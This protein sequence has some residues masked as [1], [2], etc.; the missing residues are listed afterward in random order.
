M[1]CNDLNI[2]AIGNWNVCDFQNPESLLSK[3]RMSPVYS[4]GKLVTEEEIKALSE[5]KIP[6]SEALLTEVRKT[7]SYYENLGKSRRWIRRYVKRKFN[8]VEY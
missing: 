4:I 5:T 3:I 1:Q 8:I 2:L 7:V 6:P